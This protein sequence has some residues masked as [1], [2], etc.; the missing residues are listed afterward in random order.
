MG[1]NFNSLLDFIYPPLCLH[2]DSYLEKGQKLFCSLCLEQLTFLDSA[3]RCPTC[4]TEKPPA[5]K[6]P[7]CSTRTCL[8]KRQ[9]AACARFGPAYT[10]ASSLKNGH[11]ERAPAI[12]SLLAL[13]WAQLDWPPHDCVTA[14]PGNALLA[15]QMALHMERPFV[16]LLKARFDKDAFLTRGM[17]TTKCHLIEKNKKQIWDKRVL[18]IALELDDAAFR[19]AASLLQSACAREIYTLAFIHN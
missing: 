11:E 12:V 15:E 18:L 1:F 17:F 6:C 3:E 14:L 13:Q 16:P 7:R 4:F 10:L 9:A 8:I 2:C 5:K 19:A